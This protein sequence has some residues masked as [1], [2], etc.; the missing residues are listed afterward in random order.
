MVGT[1]SDLKVSMWT[2]LPKV[3]GSRCRPLAGWESARI[4]VC[5][6][7]CCEHCSKWDSALRSRITGRANTGASSLLTSSREWRAWEY[8][9]FPLREDRTEHE[10]L[11]KCSRTTTYTGETVIPYSAR[12][13]FQGSNV[14]DAAAE[15]WN[16]L[17]FQM[18]GIPAGFGKK[19]GAKPKHAGIK[20][21]AT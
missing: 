3:E 1:V 4:S 11:Q 12:L 14:S 21:A 6:R 5:P 19:Q 8:A 15:T 18:S 17:R 9:S 16:H 13:L 10:R 20:P 7:L 2:K